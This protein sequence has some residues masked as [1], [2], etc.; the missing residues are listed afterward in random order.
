[1]FIAR[2]FAKQNKTDKKKTSK[3]HQNIKNSCHLF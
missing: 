3:Y 2:M 1:M